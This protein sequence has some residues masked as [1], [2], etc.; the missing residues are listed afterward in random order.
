MVVIGYKREAYVLQLDLC[1]PNL[2]MRLGDALPSSTAERRAS[3]REAAR[4]ALLRHDVRA[5]TEFIV[6]ACHYM[7]L[8]I[9]H[10]LFSC[11][12]WVGCSFGR[13][14][15][16]TPALTNLKLLGHDMKGGLELTWDNFADDI[17]LHLSNVKII[18]CQNLAL[19][20][21]QFSE[22]WYC[23]WKWGL[24]W[25]TLCWYKCTSLPGEI[26]WHFFSDDQ[27]WVC[28]LDDTGLAMEWVSG[29]VSQPF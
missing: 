11:D 2:P 10:I 22:S 24:W 20:N 29:R 16:S 9:C 26:V 3:A 28:V 18:I 19:P 23:F 7:H 13:W 17:C 21:L 5:L 1:L 25:E 12:I 15:T 4:R 8:W 6:S 27:R 14:Q